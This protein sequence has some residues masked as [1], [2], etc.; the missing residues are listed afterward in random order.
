MK[1]LLYLIPVIVLTLF[2]CEEHEHHESVDYKYHAHINS[3]NADDR[4][5][6]DTIS[7][8]VL[9]ESHSGE[10]VHNISVDIYEKDSKSV[11][12]SQSSHVHATSGK[13]T[14]SDTF[15][16]SEVNGVKE[17]KHYVLEAK[18]WGHKEDEGLETSTIE[19]FVHP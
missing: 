1:H 18:V 15:V 11:V 14:F 6:N 7:I 16:L 12:F 3:P 13:Y 5:M 8:S 2:S 10:T 17:D 9:F 4:N 19:F